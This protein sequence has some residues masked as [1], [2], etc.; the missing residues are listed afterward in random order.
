MANSGPPLQTLNSE[1]PLDSHPLST[2]TY[3]NLDIILPTN[4]YQ[5]E[6]HPWRCPRQTRKVSA[7]PASTPFFTNNI[8]FS[9]HCMQSSFLG[10]VGNAKEIDGLIPAFKE[11][12]N[13]MASQIH[14]STSDY[15]TTSAK[16]F[17]SDFSVSGNIYH[18]FPGCP[19][20]KTGM[21]CLYS[22][23]LFTQ[24]YLSNHNS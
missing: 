20:S 22:L 16:H 19:C 13:N 21:S 6:V 4:S 7:L 11:R 5:L 3:R 9:T 17:P 8:R 14:L 10:S 18:H 24:R 15:H 2:Q 12:L 23:F 1:G